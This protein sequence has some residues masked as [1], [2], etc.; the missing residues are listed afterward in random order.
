MTS[1]QAGTTQQALQPAITPK[2][3]G[4]A[5][6]SIG[7]RQLLVALRYLLLMTI[8]LGIGSPLVVF[9]V[10]QLAANDSANGSLV[11]DNAGVVVG[12]ELIGQQF[13]GPQWF[14][15]RPSAAGDGYDAMSSGGSN[16]S[17]DSPELLA[18]VEERRARI[19]DANGVDP[20]AVPPDALTASA[21]GLD[22]HI[23]PA[24][25]ELQ[26]NRV[27][28]ARGLPVDRVRELVSA[29]TEG[30]TLGFIGEERVN[31]L[32]LNLALAELTAAGG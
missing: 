19:A 9:G 16:L 18:L 27:A 8:V 25:A 7:G 12:S 21:S 14:A 31:V 3:S 23:S 4:A 24:Y 13:D 6:L 20:A 28:E 26:I 32:T 29:N 5:L 10:G 15:G 17:A 22:P 30:R 11:T 1:Q 2:P